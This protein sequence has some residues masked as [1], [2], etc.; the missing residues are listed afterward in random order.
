MTDFYYNDVGSW[1][2][3]KELYYNDVATWRKI[4][5]GWYNDSGVWR[6]VWSGVGVPAIT[7]HSGVGGDLSSQAAY[8]NDGTLALNG[9]VQSGEWLTSSPNVVQSTDSAAYDIMFTYISG[10]NPT[11]GNANAGGATKSGSPYATWLNLATTRSIT[12]TAYAGQISETGGGVLAFSVAIRPAGG[13]ATLAS[14]NI[15]L[16]C[17]T[18]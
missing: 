17:A 6:K 18:A 7:D 5:E 12:V 11:S 15:S 3:V 13:G 9:A 14:C 2:K 16:S 4:K 10:P 8:R 1:R